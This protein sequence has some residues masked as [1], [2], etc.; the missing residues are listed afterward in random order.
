MNNKSITIGLGIGMIFCVTSYNY[1]Y[2]AENTYQDNIIRIE[3]P[4][5]EEDNK[6]IFQT[7]TTIDGETFNGIVINLDGHFIVDSKFK[8]S[9]NNKHG[10]FENKFYTI[11]HENTK[12]SLVMSV[13]RGDSFNISDFDIEL[14]SQNKLDVVITYR[15][16][17]KIYEKE[18]T[19]EF[20]R[21]DSEENLL[22]VH[23]TEKL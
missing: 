4:L 7:I 14:P 10:V 2:F 3:K 11:S 5:V 13:T 18:Y 1:A 23:F 12:N 21:N 15:E 20:I 16:D 8:L 6:H 22:E 19:V 17:E 9:I